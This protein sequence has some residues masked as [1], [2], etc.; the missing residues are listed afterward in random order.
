MEILT[1]VVDELSNEPLYLQIYE[2]IKTKIIN[3]EILKNEKLPSKRTLAKQLNLGIITI[4]SAYAQLIDEGY[5]I[6]KERDGYYVTEIDN[7]YVLFKKKEDTPQII[8]QKGLTT[9]FRYSGIDSEHFPY[10]TIYKLSKDIIDSDAHELLNIDDPRGYLPLRKEISKYLSNSR[11]VNIAADNIVI[12]SGSEYLFQILFQ[13]LPRH[14]RYG[15]ENP[16]YER[17]NNLFVRNNINYDLISVNNNGLDI[18]ELKTKDVNVVCLTPSHQFPLGIIMPINTR[19]EIIKWTLS[20]KDRYI[21]EDDYDSEFKYVGR[22]IPA[23]KSLVD[24]NQIIYISSFSKSFASGF[25][26][27][28]MILPDSLM[29]SFLNSSSNFLCPVSLYTQKLMYHFMNQGYFEKHINKMRRIYKEKRDILVN[30]IEQYQEIEILGA[31]A[32]LHFIIKVSNV[33]EKKL[34]KALSDNNI[35]IEGLSKYYINMPDFKDGYILFGYGAIKTE[36]VEQEI[37]KIIN[38]WLSHNYIL[39]KDKL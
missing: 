16:G 12:S 22:P 18:N 8:K 29:N 21:I 35:I 3:N 20:N 39:K 27:S 10:H 23:L 9:D 4:E 7:L 33:N 38:I 25:R 13:I 11:M 28:F 14:Y 19:I 32:G 6:A 2:Q 36:I 24:S 15:I 31:E 26:T 34:I 30:V 37:L 17:L 5:I 1:L